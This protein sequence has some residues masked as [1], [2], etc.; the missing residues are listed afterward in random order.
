[1]A[2]QLFGETTDDKAPM[3]KDAEQ[4]FETMMS[5][6]DWLRGKDDAEA[7]TQA[8]W[9]KYDMEQKEAAEWMERQKR[10]LEEQ[11]DT[12]L[13]LLE[14]CGLGWVWAGRVVVIVQWLFYAGDL[15]VSF[16]ME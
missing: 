5:L 11:K 12:G 7:K 16:A 1:M 2:R 13:G 14:H 3:E 8:K 10:W 6:G 4:E 9:L 15:P